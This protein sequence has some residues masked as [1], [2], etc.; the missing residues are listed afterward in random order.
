MSRFSKVNKQLCSNERHLSKICCDGLSLT[1]SSLQSKKNVS[2]PLGR[3]K[4]I[5]LLILNIENLPFGTGGGG[6][7]GGGGGLIGGATA[8]AASVT[9][10]T[11]SFGNST[12]SASC[13]TCF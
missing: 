10:V 8:A 13:L 9:L 1:T 2:L 7:G 4:P 12:W 5:T 3:R 11:S 6:G